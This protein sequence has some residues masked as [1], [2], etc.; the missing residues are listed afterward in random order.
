MD[1]SNG[2]RGGTRPPNASRRVANRP[3]NEAA[4]SLRDPQFR[5]RV[6]QN[7]N[8]YDRKRIKDYE[9]KSRDDS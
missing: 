8:K 5:T 3:P 6:V 2:P 1:R 9:R 4:K 7:R